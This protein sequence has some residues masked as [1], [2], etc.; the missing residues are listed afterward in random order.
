MR[1]YNNEF[2]L[3]F[4]LSEKR[5]PI[6]KTEELEILLEFERN[7]FDKHNNFSEGSFKP[8]KDTL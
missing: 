2:I 4:I 3:Q 5:W 6:S 1:N 8:K 7:S